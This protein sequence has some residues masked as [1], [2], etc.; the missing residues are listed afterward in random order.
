ML[1]IYLFLISLQLR[2]MLWNIQ[3]LLS[4]PFSSYKQSVLHQALFVFLVILIIIK[5]KIIIIKKK[6]LQ[7]SPHNPDKKT[8]TALTLTVTKHS[9]QR[10]LPKILNNNVLTGRNVTISTT[11]YVCLRGA[12]TVQNLCCHRN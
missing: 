6:A 3:L 5:N 8:F 10:L 11:T 9:H 2:L 1:F 4:L 7:K 12:S